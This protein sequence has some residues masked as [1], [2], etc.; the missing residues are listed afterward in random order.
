MLAPGD[1][2]DARDL[3]LDDRQGLLG[4]GTPHRIDR[5]DGAGG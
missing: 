2:D 3:A 1:D 5:G 4:G